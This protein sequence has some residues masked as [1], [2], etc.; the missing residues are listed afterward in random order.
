[1]FVK[2]TSIRHVLVYFKDKDSHLNNCTVLENNYS[3][4]FKLILMFLFYL[5]FVLL[6][7]MQQY[8]FITTARPKN[9][10]WK[11]EKP[12]VPDS[13][14]VIAWLEDMQAMLTV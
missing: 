4:K 12:S 11:I 3:P 8:N 10:I 14:V 5:Y 2:Q 9:S 7:A 1:M 6:T 13:P